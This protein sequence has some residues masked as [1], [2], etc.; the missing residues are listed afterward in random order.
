MDAAAEILEFGRQ[1][2]SDSSSTFPTFLALEP[3]TALVDTA[4]GQAIIGAEALQELEARLAECSLR[5]V[6]RELTRM[7]KSS[8]IGGA[9][10]VEEV[11]LVPICHVTAVGEDLNKRQTSWSLFEE[12]VTKLEELMDQTWLELRPPLYMAL[13]MSQEWPVK[14]KDV[15]PDNITH[16]LAQQV[17]G[18]GAAFPGFKGMT[19]EPSERDHWK[20]PFGILKVL[21]DTRLDAPTFRTLAGELDLITEKKD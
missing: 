6:R 10:K 19:G 2:A 16:G 17:Q 21:N 1:L 8:G 14:L 7:P 5:V 18:L 12:F 11:E 20:P 13:D 3:G 9:A 15:P 4:A